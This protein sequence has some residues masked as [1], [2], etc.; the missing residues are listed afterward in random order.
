MTNK[1]KEDSYCKYILKI[2]KT[3]FFYIFFKKLEKNVN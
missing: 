2:K 1:H 3:F